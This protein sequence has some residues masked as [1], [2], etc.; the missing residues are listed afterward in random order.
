[1]VRPIRNEADYQAHLA[2]IASLMDAPYGS[3]DADELDVLATLVDRYEEQQFPIA[4]PT[5]VEAIRFRMEQMN[6]SPRELE[7]ILGS[8]ARVSEVLSGARPLSIDMMRALNRELGI[9][10]EVLIQN[11]PL[12]AAKS[13][14]KLSKPAENQLVAWGIMKARESFESLL[15]RVPRGS[16]APALLRK[17][18]TERTNAK[19]DQIALQA[20]CAAVLIRAADVTPKGAFDRKRIDAKTR[21]AVAQLSIHN[22]GPARARAMLSD[23][24]IILVILPH[25]AGTHLDGA[26]MCRADG[27]PVIALTLRRDKIDNF[28]FTLL[29]ELAHVAKHLTE[30]RGV[31]VDD[32]EISSVDEI[33]KEADQLAEDALIPADDWATLRKGAYIAG[34]DVEALAERAG[35]NVAIVAGRWQLRNKD[36]R[37]FSKLLG[38]GT[39]RAQFPEYAAA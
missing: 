23:L 13:A 1:M 29:H 18:R 27:T 21:R 22:D 2:R 37:K 17:T 4:A 33:E 19:T 31:I 10:A 26:A 32:L 14:T 39:V 6:L 8:R 12:P 30:E 16:L 34:A 28:W 3:E 25:L 9:P 36:F 35:V 11:D 24:G 38:H 7:P 15:A 5:P 20:W